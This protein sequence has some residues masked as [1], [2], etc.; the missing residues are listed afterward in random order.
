[1]CFLIK[2]HETRRMQF[3]QASLKNF[4]KI[5]KLFRLKAENI[6]RETL[7]KTQKLSSV[8]VEGH[9]DETDWQFQ[10]KNKEFYNQISKFSKLSV[11]FRKN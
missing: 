1:M 11:F 4:I 5:L 8:V 10:P 3:W 2:F 9:F 6:H 7:K